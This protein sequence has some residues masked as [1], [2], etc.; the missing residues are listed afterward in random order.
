MT[1]AIL[2]IVLSF[3]GIT[4]IKVSLS[5]YNEGSFW[6]AM[7]WFSIGEDCLLIV[8]EIIGK[9]IKEAFSQE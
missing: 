8:L 3:I 1:V 5:Y 7:W 4:C 6:G 9:L 2:L